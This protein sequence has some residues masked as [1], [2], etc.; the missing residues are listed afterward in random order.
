[1]VG[2]TKNR[3]ALYVFVFT[4][5]TILGLLIFNVYPTI[6]N[7]YTSITNRN[8][9]RPYPDCEV[10]LNNILVPFCWPGF[11]I[12]KGT[13]GRFVVIEPLLENYSKILGGIFTVQGLVNFGLVML[14][15]VPLVV[16]WRADRRLDKQLERRFTSGVVWLLGG[17]IAILCFLVFGWSAWRSLFASGDFMAVFLRTIMFV[18]LRVPL[19][20]GL[21]LLMALI[22]TSPG[23]PMRNFW[24]LVLFVPWAASSV[25]ILT[26]LIW[27]FFFREQGT[28]NQLLNLLFGIEGPVW[29]NNPITAFGIILLVDIWYSYPFFMIAILGAMASIPNDSYE[30]ADIDGASYWQQLRSITLPLIRPAIL[31][32][33]VLTSITAFQMFG[34]VWAITQG[35]PTAGAGKPGATELVMIYGWKQIFQLQ[36]YGTATAFATIIF[37]ILFVA[38]IW[39][40]RVSQLTRGAYE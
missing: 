2:M 31:P 39:S 12:P 37:L 14:C 27:Q 13:G 40:L 24:R 23:L 10:T 38:T 34:T 11:E 8:K 35:G 19:T 9:F 25:A 30:A 1:M 18:I 17:S 16:A 36:N 21:G 4:I 20:F 33:L 28:I 32:A 22:I 5:A 6:L 3:K 26:S 29:L 15:V 7:T